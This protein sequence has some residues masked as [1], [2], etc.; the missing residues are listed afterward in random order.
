MKTRIL[1]ISILM[2][3]QAY[4][5]VG[6]SISNDLALTPAQ[7]SVLKKMGAFFD[8]T[9]KENFPAKNDT[10]SYKA[11]LHCLLIDCG[12]HEAQYILQVDR[13][14]LAKINAELFTDENYGFFYNKQ[15]EKKK[16][17][18]CWYYYYHC[19][20]NSEGYFPRVCKQHANNPLFQEIDSAMKYMHSFS[21]IIF[22]S[23]LMNLHLQEIRNPEVQQFVAFV[24]WRYL[25]FCGGVDLISRKGFCT[26]CKENN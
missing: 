16:D 6:Q 21:C 23:V 12:I 2:F 22:M 24:F 18:P 13:K 8:K 3:V 14:K 4:F 17:I 5:A 26:T 25:C 11:F 9:V 1:I 10:L 15:Y 7:Q 20:Y 19:P